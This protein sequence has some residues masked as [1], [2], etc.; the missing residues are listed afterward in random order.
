MSTRLFKLALPVTAVLLLLLVIG[1]LAGVFSEK[2]QPGTTPA[3][4]EDVGELVQWWTEFQEQHPE[5]LAAARSNKSAHRGRHARNP[6]R[7][8]KPRR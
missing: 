7:P 3:V 2:V 1:W 8:R 5:L 4:T 6:R